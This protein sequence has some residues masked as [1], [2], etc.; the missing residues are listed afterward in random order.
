MVA[1]L[2]YLNWSRSHP[3]QILHLSNEEIDL[4]ALPPLNNPKQRSSI[5]DNNINKNDG[6]DDD[7]NDNDSIAIIKETMSERTD[8]LVN[9]SYRSNQALME[10]IITNR[11][12]V[13]DLLSPS[14]IVLPGGFTSLFGGNNQSGGGSGINRGHH[15]ATIIY[16]EEPTTYGEETRITNLN[17]H[18][19]DDRMMMSQFNP[20][21]I[22]ID[23]SRW[24]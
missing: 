21:R 18:P 2:I 20:D 14:Q 11:I 9:E 13:T 22:N 6:G 1:L 17:D 12:K 10:E 19:P 15:D 8:R 16:L 24:K 3:K 7:S 23:P 4:I 5:I